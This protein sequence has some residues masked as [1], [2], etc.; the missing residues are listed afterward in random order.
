MEV[1]LVDLKLK[2]MVVGNLARLRGRSSDIAIILEQP[3][4]EQ[5][6]QLQ[7]LL[8]ER[9]GKILTIS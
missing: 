9:Q 8:A 6:F 1:C 4:E 7:I 2:R 3:T 5:R